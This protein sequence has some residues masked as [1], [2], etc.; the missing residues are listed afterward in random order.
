[1]KTPSQSKSVLVAPTP[2]NGSVRARD[3]IRTMD[4]LA[5]MAEAARQQGKTVVLA[6]GVFDLVHMGHI[7]HLEAARREG[8]VLLV[9]VTADAL[10]NKGPGRPIF[11]EDMRAELLAA[12]G[13]VDG[14]GI[15][16]YESSEKAVAAI[17]P[18][19]YVKGSDYEN[20]EEDL[21]G[22]IVAEKTAVESY[23]GRLV[24]TKDITFSSS[25]LINKYLDVYD[26]PLQDYLERM[27]GTDAVDRL[28][29][30]ID[31]VRDTRVLIVGDAIL[32]EYQYVDTMGKAPKENIIAT[33]FRESELF[34]GGVFAVANNVSN[35]CAEVEV[36]TCLGTLDDHEDFIR[37][38]LNPNVRLTCVH[39]E[40][41]PTTR[42]L[43]FINPS[44]MHKLFEVYFFEESPLPAKLRKSLNDLIADRIGDYD[45][46]IANDFGHGLIESPTIQLLTENSR[47]LAVNTQ[48][49]SANLGYNLITKYRKADFVCIDGPEAQLAARDKFSPIETIA[50]KALPSLVDC[51]RFIITHGREGCVTY[52]RATGITVIPAFTKTVVDTV[53]AGDAF[54]AVTAPLTA[55]GG[56]LDDVGFVGNAAGA[57]KVGIV[58]HRGSIEKVPLIRYIATLLK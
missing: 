27:R 31:G 2:P 33:R 37:R 18:D 43:R 9:T 19:V 46:V 4:E 45:M 24:I 15:S 5:A 42:K 44:Y 38:H 40:D 48:T 7:R 26:R 53:G 8:D 58:G 35:F 13:C 17:R 54:L 34:A 29:A 14:V 23:G 51:E 11:P 16:R 56:A 12:I 50:A 52:D 30:L 47:F 1:M 32:D 3:K 36:I 49:N 28:T 57:I 21:T 41:V 10:V 55:T 39:R 22:K 6:H 20:P 25:T